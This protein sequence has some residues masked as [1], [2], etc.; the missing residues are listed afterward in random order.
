MLMH[1]VKV[2]SRCC[3]EVVSRHGRLESWLGFLAFQNQPNRT[4]ESS[5]SG[6][7]LTPARLVLRGHWV[8]AE[9]P[10][11]EGTEAGTRRRDGIVHVRVSRGA[12][13]SDLLRLPI[14]EGGKA[15]CCASRSATP[16]ST[17][18]MQPEDI[19]QRGATWLN[20]KKRL[21]VDLDKTIKNS[22]F[23]RNTVWSIW[24]DTPSERRPVVAQKMSLPEEAQRGESARRKI[25]HYER[26]NSKLDFHEKQPINLQSQHGFQSTTKTL[27]QLLDQLVEVEIHGF[28]TKSMKNEIF[29]GKSTKENDIPPP[30]P[31]SSSGPNP[32]P[33]DSRSYFTSV[34]PETTSTITSRAPGNQIKAASSWSSP[35]P[36]QQP[37]PSSNSPY[38][39]HSE[40]IILGRKSFSRLFTFIYSAN[41]NKYSNYIR[42]IQPIV[43]KCSKA[44]VRERK[45]VNNNIV[46][47][48]NIPCK[49]A[50]AVCSSKT[51]G[52]IL[53]QSLD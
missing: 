27:F 20:T 36:L 38:S 9:P 3:K 24:H 39:S 32:D 48:D 42:W 51:D 15:E 8:T 22:K 50:R 45:L 25:Y 35:L 13:P 7:V 21:T 23:C 19:E 29:R 28:I 37:E 44:S 26:E 43:L 2:V 52:R 41:K 34:F 18:R 14:P 6:Y 30:S 5:G 17:H 16:W 49:K 4:C 10:D 40:E 53:L 11:D 12:Y 1:Y 31:S 33:L 47:F 46:W